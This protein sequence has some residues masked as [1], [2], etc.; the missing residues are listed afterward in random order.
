ME[1]KAPLLLALL[2]LAS[3]LHYSFAASG[4]TNSF[5]SVPDLEKSMYTQIDGFPCVRLLNL[6]GEIGCSN[7][8]RGNVVAP[9]VR[10][11]NAKELTEP[12]SVLVSPDEFESLL[13]R[14]LS[15]SNFARN[16]AGILV[17]SG[18]HVQNSLKGFSPDAKFPQAEFAPYR[19]NNFEWNP[20]GSGI[21]W[22]AYN[23]PIFLL[24]QNSTST[25]QEAALKNEKNKK[26][27]TKVVSEF[28]LVMQ[29]TKSGTHDSDTCL[30]EGTC[31][32]LGGYSVWSALPPIKTSSQL[33]GKPIVLV[34]TS[35]DSASFFRDKSLGAE[36]PISGLIASLAVVDALS[37]LDGLGE[38]NKQLVFVVLTGETWGYLGSRRI[39]LEFDQ[40]S[41]SVK[42]LNLENIETVLE[43]GSVG[44]S[45]PQGIKT[46]FAHTAGTTSAVNGTLNALQHAKDSLASESIMVK[47]AS[48]SNP[49]VPPSSLMTFLRKKPLISGLVLEDFDSA[50]S[51]EFYHS[52]FDDLSNINSSSIT[53]AASLVART[54][55][56]LAG[57]ENPSAI[58]NIKINSS[59]VDEL[60]SCLLNCDPGLSCELVKHYISPSTACPSHYV[61]V[62]LGK[63]SSTPYPSYV[64]DVSRFVWNFLADKTSIP[65]KN[66]SSSCPK[67][68]HDVDE[69]CIREEA[70]GK[71]VCVIST[72]RYVPAYS[73][74]LK[75]DESVES[76]TV[77]PINSSDTMGTEDPI[78]TE[79]NWDTI[80]LR[81]YTVQTSTYDN[82]ILLLGI[83]ITFLSYLVIAI[84][85]TVIRKALKQD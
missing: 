50:F 62:I 34:M 13:S 20:A 59:L 17:E 65:S 35:M 31:L 1:L 14:L 39:F 47:A 83:I 51:N 16:V 49:G 32:P 37:H 43:I 42:G 3:R 85:R 7:P 75:Y 76:W 2:C 40:Q 82:L 11:K 70:D 69:L 79:S 53:A 5:E 27:Y 22:K 24:S 44:K 54:L 28:D 72:T 46:F 21:M 68:C 71:G 63:P 29:T 4:G 55:F 67:D 45:Y 66:V 60:I 23:F 64:G 84:G 6:S 57:G 30:K 74:R 19:N 12:A 15:D 52:H 80:N 78:W 61:G 38:L 9:V 48:T 81:L 56:I 73:T 8:G 25:L 10:F 18:T 58:N 36:S 26:S 77:L 33:N 41:D